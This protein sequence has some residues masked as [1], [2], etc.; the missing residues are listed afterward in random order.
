MTIQPNDAAIAL[1]IPKEHVQLTF[2]TEK[3]DPDSPEAPFHTE[4]IISARA[5]TRCGGYVSSL[6][7]EKHEKFHEDLAR[8][9]AALDG[10][11]AAAP[12]EKPEKKAKKSKKG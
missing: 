10:E 8:C 9:L 1:D 12:A 5:C 7:I 3:V 4:S 6:R 11:I 2:S